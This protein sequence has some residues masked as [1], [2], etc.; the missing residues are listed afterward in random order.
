MSAPAFI[1]LLVALSGLVL[2]A[3]LAEPIAD[4]LLSFFS[5]PQNRRRA[6]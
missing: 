4:A 1:A 5:K 6:K 2:L 3:S